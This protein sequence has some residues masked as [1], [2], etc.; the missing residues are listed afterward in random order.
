[1]NKVDLDHHK[2][3]ID[4][5]DLVHPDKLIQQIE[6]YKD[7]LDFSDIVPIS[8]LHGNN[9][10]KLLQVI[11]GYLPEG[12]MYYPADRVSDNPEYLI[13]S[14]IIR[15][16]ALHLTRQE[17][18]NADGAETERRKADERPQDRPGV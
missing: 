9:I 3:K 8:A 15:E 17:I 2:N 7:K 12:P 5:I 4:K 10:E 14:G 6:V 18:S 11:E 16:K 1:M 13:V